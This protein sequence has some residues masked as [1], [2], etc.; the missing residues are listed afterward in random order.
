MS[1][2]WE[3]RF[4]AC[5]VRPGG[6]WQPGG[7]PVWQGG[8]AGGGNCEANGR[9]PPLLATLRGPHARDFV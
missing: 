2:S 9:L 4:D 6:A 3:K 8:G 1:L 5:L 7:V